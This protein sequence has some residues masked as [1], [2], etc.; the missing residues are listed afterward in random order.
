MAMQGEQ[1][2]K[3]K[4]FLLDGSA[5]P[6]HRV[7]VLKALVNSGDPEATETLLELLQSASAAKSEEVYEKKVKELNKTIEEMESGPLRMG[8]YVDDG[9]LAAGL[10]QRVHVILEDGASVYP[11]AHNAELASNLRSGESVLL[12]AQAKALLFKASAQTRVGEEV[13]FIRRLDKNL[14]EVRVRDEEEYVFWA[15]ADLIDKL[16]AGE[17]CSGQKVLACSR[18]RFAF[19]A[20]PPEEGM[21][22]YLY[23]EQRPVPN[24]VVERDIG[25]PPQFIAQLTEHLR[26]EMTRPELRRKYRLRGSHAKLLSG[27]SGSGKTLAI[28]GFTRCAYEVMSEH[29]GVPIDDLPPRVLRM[30]MCNVLSKWLGESDKRL[31]RFFDEVIELA[32]EPYVGPDGAAHRLPVIAIAE[33][34]DALGRHRGADN[35]S[36]YDRILTT[37][38]QRLDFTKPDYN[39][40][41]IIF[42]FTTNCPQL[43]DVALLR[44]MGASVEHFG[45]LT[46]RRAFA[47]VLD[48]HLAD[49]P[50]QSDNGY[51]ADERREQLTAE[52]SAVLFAP[53]SHETP[54]VEAELANAAERL[55]FYRRDFLTGG[56]VDRAVHQACEE[57][58]RAERDGDGRPGLSTEVLM[59]ALDQQVRNIVLQ[60]TKYN[61]RS[62]VDLPDSVH[63]ADLRRNTQPAMSPFGLLRR[64]G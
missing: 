46:D 7:E 5:P 14:V 43:V 30:R 29:V 20:L 25:N 37:A 16:D 45:R 50:I 48:K 24:V 13:K 51:R 44:R 64:T 32:D 17:V 38:L 55:S 54:Q 1:P 52:V 59:D 4:D 8:S 9:G 34:V 21:S 53:N 12:D 35:D 49:R 22:R 57:A 6:L 62:Y 56:L 63:I 11:Y 18:R 47:A 58:H 10:A 40:R 36:I 42:L 19:D 28:E 31:N 41:V 2:G 23:L 26:D 61:I 39:E 27:V 60:L 3:A 33:E 15:A